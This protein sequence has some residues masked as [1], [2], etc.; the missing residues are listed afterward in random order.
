MSIH[1]L[2]KK[3][4]GGEIEFSGLVYYDEEFCWIKHQ[5]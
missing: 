2:Q 4:I 3:I 5:P 1:E